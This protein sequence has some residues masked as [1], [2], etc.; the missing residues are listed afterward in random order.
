MLIAGFQALS[1]LDYPG[2]VCSIVFTQGCPL[3]CI[4]CHNPELI[5]LH[6][7]TPECLLSEQTVLEHLNKRKHI[8]TGVCI[9]GGEPT[10]HHDLPAFVRRV[11]KLGL[12]V[13]LDTNGVHPRMLEKLIKANLLDFIAMD[14]KHI[15]ARYPEVIGS[16]PTSVLD[17]CQT[18]FNLIQASSVSHEFRTTVYS[19]VH[20]ASDLYD[21][22]LQLKNGE[23]YALQEIS[24]E[25]TFNPA[26]VKTQKLDLEIIAQHIKA[27]RP[28]LEIEVRA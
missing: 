13:K 2:V 17:N 11:K 5:P 27:Q 9:T 12:L 7:S 4:Y 21:I 14:I 3:R 16:V 19:G 26:L 23:H 22:A 8:V 25:K 15:W 10:I 28:D 20:S 6:S 1:L 18:T 24:Y